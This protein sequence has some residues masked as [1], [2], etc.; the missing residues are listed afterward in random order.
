MY[1]SA[2]AKQ[3]QDTQFFTYWGGTRIKNVT[4]TAKVFKS[5][6][7][8]LKTRGYPHF[9]SYEM[10]LASLFNTSFDC[11]CE[12]KLFRLYFS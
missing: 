2:R 3:V 5:D 10:E 7:Q 6:Q 4:G 9:L 1:R 11:G 8:V 12:Q